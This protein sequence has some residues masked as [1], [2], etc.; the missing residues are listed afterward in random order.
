[1]KE[2]H[3]GSGT[4]TSVVTLGENRYEDFIILLDNNDEKVL[5][6]RDR[7][8]ASG[9]GA[10]GPAPAGAGP[11]VGHVWRI[12]GRSAQELDGQLALGSGSP[13]QPSE[14]EAAFPGDSFRVTLRV[15]GKWRAV[16]WERLPRPP[17]GVPALAALA[18]P[19]AYFVVADWNDW[20]PQL[21]GGDAA[22]QK[23]LHTL[24]VQIPTFVK[25]GIF[26]IVRN[27]DFGQT[28][29]PA[30]IVAQRGVGADHVLGPTSWHVG[31]VWSLQASS[32]ASRRFRI[33]FQRQL[34]GGGF[35]EEQ[36]SLSFI[37][38]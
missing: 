10:E 21:M 28:F 2:E 5:Y 13:Q 37:A 3:L 33:E 32:S 38:L 30:R 34:P 17:A 1:M 22:H 8:G 16:T 11:A 12:E 4:Y 23:G 9:S 27:K 36:R 15:A 31:G 19:S 6:P 29:A 35:G 24:E 18:A 20:S 26:R 7:F 25:E 14:L